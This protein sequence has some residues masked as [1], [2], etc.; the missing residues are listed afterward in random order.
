MI[1]GILKDFILFYIK[2]IIICCVLYF[3]FNNL[4][5]ITI[6]TLTSFILYKLNK[7][8]TIF[9]IYIIL[10]NLIN[11]LIYYTIIY[12]NLLDNPLKN[13]IA[14]SMGIFIFILELNIV[15]RKIILI[16]SII[17]NFISNKINNYQNKKLDKYIDS[18]NY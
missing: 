1:Q 16:D 14:I 9:L 8:I 12:F 3:A 15:N 7:Y 10:Y 5:Y 17:E 18:F 11:L 4:K 2:L 6:I 13:S